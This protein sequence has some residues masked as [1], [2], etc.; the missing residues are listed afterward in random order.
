MAV[1]VPVCKRL[2]PQGLASASPEAE[3]EASGGSRRRRHRGSAVTQQQPAATSIARGVTILAVPVCERLMDSICCLAL[4]SLSASQAAE[5]AA[6][7]EADGEAA[8]GEWS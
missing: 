4:A 8:K 5:R 2:R 7:G 6:S 1:T 3:L